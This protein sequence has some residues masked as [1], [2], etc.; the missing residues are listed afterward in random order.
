LR[1]T[2]GYFPAQPLR[3][4]LDGRATGRGLL[5]VEG[6]LAAHR[7]GADEPVFERAGTLFQP[8]D[9]MPREA[10]VLEIDVGS[11]LPGRYEGSV[12]LSGLTPDGTRVG[13][14]APV[15]VEFEL[16]KADPEGVEIASSHQ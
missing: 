13:V 6:T 7:A 11:L 8:V 3:I 5:V 12:S 16:L 10:R 1:W 14:D 4:D 9:E 2:T 15:P